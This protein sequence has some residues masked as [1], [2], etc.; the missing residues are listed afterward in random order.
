MTSFKSQLIDIKKKQVSDLSNVA[1]A[2]LELKIKSVID[3]YLREE[4]T[5]DEAIRLIGA[6]MIE[7]AEKQLKVVFQVGYK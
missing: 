7:I 2:L 4:I 3:K 1:K 5:R 6:K